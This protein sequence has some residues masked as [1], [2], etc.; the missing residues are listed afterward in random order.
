MANNNHKANQGNSSKGTKG[1][2]WCLFK[3]IS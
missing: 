3:S 1:Y 2:K